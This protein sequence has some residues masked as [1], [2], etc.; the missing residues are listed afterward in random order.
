M[1]QIY[2]NQ[3]NMD[4]AFHIPSII[5]SSLI[6]S[7]INAILRLLSLSE[8]SILSIKL[9]KKINQSYIKAKEIKA[10]LRIK[11]IFYIIISTILVIFYWY[12]I[13]CFCA[14]YKNTQIILI[15]DSLCSFGLSQLY[16]F[17]FNIIIGLFR[18]SSLKAQ[19][20]DKIW[21]YKLSQLLSMFI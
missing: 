14:V 15:T 13:S 21:I 19:K 10:F 17:G 2:E 7:V 3:G 4:L 20:Q 11:F 16:P 5:Y 9:E 12:Y 6:S 18:I 8:N 1:H